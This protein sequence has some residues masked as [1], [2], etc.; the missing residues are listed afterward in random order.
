MASVTINGNT[1][2]D[3]S[4]ASTGLAA[5]GHRTRFIPLVSDVVVVAAEVE[6]DRASAAS[7]AGT[8]TTQAG[9]AT[10]QAGVS[11]TQAG[12][13][14][15]QAGIATT[16]AGV[17]A[18]QAGNASVSAAAALASEQNAHAISESG[19]PSQ[20]GHDGDYLASNGVTTSWQTIAVPAAVPLFHFT[21]C[22]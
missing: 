5:G 19:L 20:A 18:T 2:S 7:G 12:I 21:N 14:T 8:A 9:I 3:D 15:T 4:N 6:S 1:Y 10:T 11:T 16:Q 13:A 22:I 17:A